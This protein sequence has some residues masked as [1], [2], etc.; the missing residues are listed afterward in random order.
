MEWILNCIV[1][2]MPV[3]IGPVINVS[4]LSNHNVKNIFK[5]PIDFGKN[6]IDNKRIFGDNKTWKGLFLSIII[7]TLVSIVW[8]AICKYILS[9][10]SHNWLYIN[11]ENT[12]SFNIL[13]GML[14][15]LSY[16]LFEL[17]NSF[18]KRRFDIEPGKSSKISGKKRIP[19]VILDQFDSAIGAS[20][21]L[22]YFA[23]LTV[24]EYVKAVLLAGFLH[25]LIVKIMCYFKL[26]EAV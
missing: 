4:I 22:W 24:L 16:S 20:L 12:L 21:V 25:Y 14:F 19:F 13:I 17:P 15:G 7:C 8:G 3:V 26:K 6:F 9:I 1:S 5:T 11:Y 18:L 10:G 2:A 23:N